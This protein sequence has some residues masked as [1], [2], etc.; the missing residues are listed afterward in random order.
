LEIKNIMRALKKDLRVSWRGRRRWWC[1]EIEAVAV[2]CDSGFAIVQVHKEV[3]IV[4]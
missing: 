1:N 2:A 4:F 3:G